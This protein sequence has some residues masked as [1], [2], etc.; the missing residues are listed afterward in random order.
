MKKIILVLLVFSMMFSVTGCYWNAEVQSNEIGLIMKDGV[1]ISETVGSGRYSDMGWFADLKP[2]DVSA[3]TTIWTDNDMW[4]S[5][6]QSVKFSVSVTYA[7]ERNNIATMFSKYNLETKD[8]TALEK[9]VLTRIP[10]IAKQITTSLTLDQ[11]IGGTETQGREFMQKQMYDLLKSELDECFIELLDIG[12][13]DIGVDELYASK[14]KEKAAAKV[15]SELAVQKT[16]QLAEQVK[17]EAA[18]TDV[19]LEVARRDKLVAEEK[20]KIFQTSAE[21]FELER[22]KLLKDVLGSS[23]K[24]YFIPEGA[25]LSL[26]LAGNSQ[27][28]IIK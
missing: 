10:R 17:Q 25:D 6:K 5:D 7:R 22:L 19:A 28:P 8:D 12:V 11:M 18:Q 13:N 3:K 26:Y 20:N 16:A 9:L 4:T 1:S 27:V 15:E 24:I 2:I 21:A 14:L 23:D